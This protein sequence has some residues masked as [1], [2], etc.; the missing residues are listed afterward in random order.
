MVSRIAPTATV[1]IIST[2]VKPDCL[3][4]VISTASGRGA[5]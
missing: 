4:N 3:F 5:Y 1:M 2:I